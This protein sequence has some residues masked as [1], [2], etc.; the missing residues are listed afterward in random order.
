MQDKFHTILIITYKV[1]FNLVFIF[2]IWVVKEQAKN[3]LYFSECFF[4]NKFI[5]F[6]LNFKT[7]HQLQ[8]VVRPKTHFVS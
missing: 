8:Q 7:T 2:S 1:M 6:Q 5:D 4:G 3:S